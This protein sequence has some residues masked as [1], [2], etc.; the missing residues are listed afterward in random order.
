[1]AMD[2]KKHR[3]EAPGGGAA[4]ETARM[5]DRDGRARDA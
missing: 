5:T 2:L 1:M 4:R 3:A